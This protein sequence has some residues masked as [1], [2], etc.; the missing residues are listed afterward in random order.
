MGFA[1]QILW[2]GRYDR[3]SSY[4]SSWE[5]WR[6]EILASMVLRSTTAFFPFLVPH[7]IRPTGDVHVVPRVEDHV[8]RVRPAIE[9]R[10][11]LT[12]TR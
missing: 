8:A 2:Y 12:S 7:E 6:Y 5:I 9:R 1:L 3:L 4:R 11:N 10:W